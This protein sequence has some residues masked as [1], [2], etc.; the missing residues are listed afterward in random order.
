MVFRTLHA[1]SKEAVDTFS[2]IICRLVLK[3]KQQKKPS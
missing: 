3:V 2:L 1:S